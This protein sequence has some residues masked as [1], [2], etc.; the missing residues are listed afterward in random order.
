MFDFFR[1]LFSRPGAARTVIL[2]EQ[3]TMSTPRQ[4][5]VRP[6]YAIYAAVIGS[7]V[8]ATLIV[9]MVVLTPLRQ[10]LIGPSSADL[11]GTA[12][13]NALRAAA[14]EDS[15]QVQYR[16][17][18]QLRALITGDLTDEAMLDPE[19]IELPSDEDLA[20][21]EVSPPVIPTSPEASGETPALPLRGLRARGEGPVPGSA[22]EAY[23]SSLRL[24][25]PPPLNGVVSRGFDAGTGHLGLDIAADTGTPVRSIGEGYVVFADWT[26]GGGWTVAVQHAGGYLSV[27]KHNGRLLKRVGDRVRNRETVALSGDSGEVTSGPHLHLEI[28]HDGLALDPATFLLAPSRGAA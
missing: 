19:S 15:I 24:P 4:Y 25:V 18:A 28:W 5:E 7:V 13:E 9:V 12:E 26:N 1:D 10:V 23:L 17:I 11:R 8:V 14:L 16:Q 27:Y 6:S 20:D 2:L 22:A 3:D 21:I